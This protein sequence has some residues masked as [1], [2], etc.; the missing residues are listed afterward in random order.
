MRGI[1]VQGGAPLKNSDLGFRV[2][3]L[4]WDLGLRVKKP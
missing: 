1:R 2:E 4:V 3:L